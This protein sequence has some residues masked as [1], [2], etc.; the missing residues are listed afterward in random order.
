MCQLANFGHR[1]W[2]FVAFVILLL[3]LSIPVLLLRL[4]RLSGLGLP[5][6]Y[7]RSARLGSA[8]LLLGL[9][10]LFG[11]MVYNVLTFVPSE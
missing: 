6:A 3:A 7:L 2:L 9:V 1:D 11:A 10:V 5:A 8:I 4:R